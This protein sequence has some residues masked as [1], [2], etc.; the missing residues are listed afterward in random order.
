[1]CCLVAIACF[2]MNAQKHLNESNGLED[3]TSSRDVFI[4]VNRDVSVGGYFSYIDSLI[5][6][7]DTLL[8]YKLNEHLLVHANSWIIDSLANTDYYRLM[9]KD[10]FVYDQKSLH[11]LLKGQNLRIPDSIS[12]ERLLS[13]LN[14]TTIV[15]NIPEFKLRIYQD[16]LMYT[17]PIRVGK[18]E[19]K[20]LKMGDRI[21]NLKTRTGEGTIVSHVKNPDYYNPVDG[22]KYYRT[23]R[24]DKRVTK[25]PQIP[26]LETEINGVRYG[27][28]IHPTTNPKT[29]GKAYSNGCIGTSEAAAWILY[30]YAPIGTRISIQYNLTITTN[31]GETMILED[32]YQ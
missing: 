19:K 6:R 13:A 7:Y 18:N 31:Q 4:K 14:K 22:R 16:S 30:Y 20:Y 12:A 21:T 2:D 3:V 28:L 23:T 10:S 5:Q 1:M 15:V 27:Q 32:I 11:V 8:P 26:W 29:L 24:D 17:F 25:L 9:E